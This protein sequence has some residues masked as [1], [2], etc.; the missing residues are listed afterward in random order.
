M[1][2]WTSVT[3]GQVCADGVIQ[4]GPFGSQLHAED[5]VAAGVPVVMPANIASGRIEESGIARITEADAVRLSR[6]RMKV[7]DIVYSRRGDITRCAR[8]TQREAG[9][10]CG[11]G[12]LLVRPGSGADHRWLAYW[13]STPWTHEWLYRHAVGATMLNLNTSILASLPV[14][15]PPVEDQRRIG[16]LLGALDDLIEVNRDVNRYTANLQL[17]IFARH[18]DGEQR[19]RL[20]DVAAIT[21]GQS[22]PGDTYNESG[23]GTVFYQGTRDFGWRFP[24]RRVWTSQPSR[25]AGAGDI[26]VSVRAPVGEVNVATEDTALGRGVGA[27]RAVG[28]P[29]TLLQA[30]LVDSQLW[31][32]HQGTGTVFAS[33]NRAGMENL[34]VPWVECD[35]V[36]S[37]L[38]VLDDSILELTRESE[39]LVR[40]R[41]ELLPLLMSGRVRVS[42]DFEVA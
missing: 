3:L 8:I 17:A 39:D 21:M 19:E 30:L 29:A 23:E 6:H 10:L 32:M 35:D 18:W 40:A 37:T 7:G 5:Y 38:A 24:G 15:L 2:D 13:L 28:R 12:C 27:L 42:E 41:D 25:M 9:W 36:E 26:L 11:T 34:M 1:A 4:T 22:P 33:V 20:V 14:D 16:A 31:D